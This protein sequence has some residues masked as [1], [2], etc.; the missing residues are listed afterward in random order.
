M[1]IHSTWRNYYDA[2]DMFRNLRAE[3]PKRNIEVLRTLNGQWQVVDLEDSTKV[4]S[5]CGG[6]A[7]AN[8]H[9]FYVCQECQNHVSFMG[10]EEYIDIADENA[11]TSGIPKAMMKPILAV[12]KKKKQE[13]KQKA[14]DDKASLELLD[15]AEEIAITLG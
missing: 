1:R 15:I 5:I 4:C 9:G 14:E 3:N 11:N 7:L 12:R 10:M 6:R 8:E 2:T 13:E